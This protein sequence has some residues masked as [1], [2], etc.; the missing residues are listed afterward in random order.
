MHE[1]NE[2]WIKFSP[3]RKFINS[4]N[5]R[6]GWINTWH[7]RQIDNWTT[8][9]NGSWNSSAAKSCPL[10]PNTASCQSQFLSVSLQLA[11]LLKEQRMV[12][13]TS[14]FCFSMSSTSRKKRVWLCLF[15]VK[16]LQEMEMVSL[17]WVSCLPTNKSTVT[18]MAC[19]NMTLP[20]DKDGYLV[21]LAWASRMKSQGNP[22]WNAKQGYRAVTLGDMNIES[23]LWD[24]IGA[25]WC[26]GKAL[27]L[28]S[29]EQKFT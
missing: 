1:R 11:C 20:K 23:R 7:K 16:I 17:T 25:C 8:R 29:K 19:S 12:S 5:L 27:N 14:E 2:V 24:S 15:K 28:E 26:R 6:K 4:Q 18:R 3:R 10:T 22:E 21:I 13:I 9:T